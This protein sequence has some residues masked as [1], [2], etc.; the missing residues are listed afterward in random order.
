[1]SS[2]KRLHKPA[3]A[4]FLLSAT[5]LA[6]CNSSQSQ[7][8]EQKAPYQIALERSQ[9]WQNE[10]VY[11]MAES[12]ARLAVQLQTSDPKTRYQ[13]FLALQAQETE[14][15]KQQEAQ[16]LADELAKEFQPD[17]PEHKQLSSFASREGARE[18][19]VALRKAI[20]HPSPELAKQLREFPQELRTPDYWEVA[21]QAY[22]EMKLWKEAGEAAKAWLPSNPQ[23]GL[24]DRARQMVKEQEM[25]LR[26]TP[27][28]AFTQLR[29]VPKS[30][31]KDYL[32]NPQ[33]GIRGELLA[34]LL[35]LGKVAGIKS[36]NSTTLLVQLQIVDPFTGKSQSSKLELAYQSDRGAQRLDLA[37][38]K[39]GTAPIAVSDSKHYIEDD[40][41]GIH[42]VFDSNHPSLTTIIQALGKP[43]QEQATPDPDEFSRYK[44]KATEA[45]IFSQNN[46][47]VD[48]KSYS[49]KAVL[50]FVNVI[51]PRFRLRN[52]L[53][54]G[55]HLN[56]FRSRY[57]MDTNPIEKYLDK[58]IINGRFIDSESVSTAALQGRELIL[59]TDSQ[60]TVL[61][62]RIKPRGRSRFETFAR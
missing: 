35:K 16:K 60:Q 26:G 39:F 8:N 46:L 19:L 12:E 48:I 5:C 36:P 20:G 49:E 61:A 40:F 18:K 6:G 47:S 57:Q 1:M 56:E 28:E 54:V 51:G 21:F 38:C 33:M 23:S 62:L 17:S 45:L 34:E 52:G 13:L 4:I 24:A 55:S 44:P 10:K 25:G 50:N 14:P 7:A 37:K 22:T 29:K 30:E 31:W 9:K 41:S 3:M 59:Y 11:V 42:G 58:P 2:L 15:Q 27:T 43:V 32:L 53:G